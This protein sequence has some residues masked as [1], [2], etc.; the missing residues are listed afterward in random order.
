MTT[1][2][3]NV[4]NTKIVNVAPGTDPTDAVNVD[5]LTQQG[6]ELIAKGMNFAGND[7]T[8]HRNLGDTLVIKGDGSTDGTYSGANL[9]T[10]VDPAGVINLQMADA[11]KFGNVVINDG[12][13]G[14]ITGVTAGVAPTDAVN[15]SQLT[16]VKATAEKG[17]NLQANGGPATNVAPGATVN[18]VD[19]TNTKVT[20]TGNTMKVDVVDNPTFSGEVTAAGGMKVSDHLTVGANTDIDMGGNQIHNVGAGVADTDAVNVGQLKD[21]QGQTQELSDRAVKY[22]V[23]NGTVNHNS[24]TMEGVGGTT[25]GNVAA[26]VKSTDAVNVSQLNDVKT[27]VTN[28]SNTVNNFAGDQSAD[29][30]SKNG[31]GIRY[32]RTN[33]AGL[34]VSDSSAQG[35]GSTAV[36]YDAKATGESALA[37][38]RNARATEANSVALGAGSVTAAAVVTASGT[39]GGQTYQFAGAKP[40]S[41]VS[42]GDRDAERTVTNVAAG[43]ISAE[44]TDA[45][46][47][48][49]L[50]ATNQAVDLNTQGIGDLNKR[51]DG[52]SQAINNLGNRID[53]VKRDANAGTASAM[54]LAGLPQSVLPG[55]GMVAMAGSTYGGASALALG[56]SKLSDSGKWV[57]KGS[58][59]TNTRGNVGA[60]IG[61]GFHW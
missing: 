60:A 32:V 6:D 1:G 39:V 9:R 36:G 12:G 57:Y 41:T 43:R 4:A 19:G 61:A 31:R 42:V 13:S 40:T 48:S 51:V 35:Q 3:I 23:N 20:V 16:D 59:T 8:V 44:S 30:T 52:N 21:L 5:Q 47:G 58:V 45:I 2:G 37:L 15:V 7:G 34:T 17:W 24:V 11:P 49:Q 55:K 38:G 28:L 22:D 54:A 53:N 10:Y 33:D 18:V 27:D 26:G 25:I 46:N 14:R 50:Y 56:V 29:Y